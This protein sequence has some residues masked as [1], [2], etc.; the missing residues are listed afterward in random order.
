MHTVLTIIAVV[1]MVAFAITVLCFRDSLTWRKRNR[2]YLSKQTERANLT[3]DQFCCKVGIAPSV[4]TIIGIVRANLAEFGQCNALKI[5]PEDTLSEY[6][7]DYDDD[8]AMLVRKMG[9]I[10][11]FTEYSFP[12]E[13]VDDVG[14]FTKLLLIMKEQ[15]IGEQGVIP[16]VRE[17]EL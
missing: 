3:D 9:I 11:G 14:G 1:L 8:V 13:V 17:Q 16:N 12:L 7:L 5:Y 10:P 6:G 2:A 4:S 15:R